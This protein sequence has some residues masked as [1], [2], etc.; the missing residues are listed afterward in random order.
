MRWMNYM[1]YEIKDPPEDASPGIRSSTVAFWKKALSFFMVNQLMVW[2]KVSNIGNPTRCTQ[3][4]EL[5]K[6]SR[7]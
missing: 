2:S 7:R 3:L 5:I 1:V 6:K 4:N